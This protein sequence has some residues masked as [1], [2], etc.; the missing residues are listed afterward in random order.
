M[1]C[2]FALIVLMASMS[3]HGRSAFLEKKCLQNTAIKDRMLREKVCSCI[4]SN[5][6]AQLNPARLKKLENI[7]RNKPARSVAA[8]DPLLKPILEMDYEIYK[9]CGKDPQWK[10]IPEDMGAPDPLEE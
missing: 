4:Q 9:N 6:E 2:A 8:R 3:A 10:Y 7:Y 1:R 5:L